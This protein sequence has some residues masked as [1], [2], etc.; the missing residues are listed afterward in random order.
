MAVVISSSL[1]ISPVD[2]GGGQ[3][4]ANNPIIGYETLVTS[5]NVS[6][7]TEATGYPASNLANPS[8]ALLWKGETSSPEADEYITL[9]LNTNELVDYVGIAKHNFGTAQ[10]TV[11]LEVLDA[12]ASPESWTEI[13][14]EFIP[15][16]N[17]PILMR[18]TPQAVTS[19]RIRLQPGSAAP[20]AGVVYAGPLLVF[21]RRIYVGHTPMNYGRSTKITNARSE[22]GNF[23]G[24]IVLSQM[25]RTKIDLQNLTP[26]WVRSELVPFIEA[27]KD[28][29]FFFAWRPS[30]YP[31]ECGYAWM[32][33]DPQPSNAL[34]N[35]FMQ[36][37]MELSGI[38]E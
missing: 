19:L 5:S 2:S 32:T 26:T 29:P 15:S 34:T 24:R 16:D 1:T 37:S 8:T 12:D 25:T 22:S 11:S 3:I 21:Q 33:N 27:S 36:V 17:Q 28:T 31:R 13:V 6:A 7:T 38:F 35:G 10:I 20:Q 18:F 9:A 4:T 30:D 23:L 14:S